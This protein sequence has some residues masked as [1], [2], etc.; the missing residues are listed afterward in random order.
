MSAN[1]GCPQDVE[2]ERPRRYVEMVNGIESWHQYGIRI[3]SVYPEIGGSTVVNAGTPLNL[4]VAVDV[5][6]DPQRAPQCIFASCWTNIKTEENPCGIW[7]EVFL[8]L[9]PDVSSSVH[10]NRDVLQYIYQA[11][12]VPTVCDTYR[13]TFLLKWN[14]LLLWF[15]EFGNDAFVDVV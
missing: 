6:R 10:D 11:S 5:R 9:N 14:H 13:M 3:P 12:L 8:P 4:H 1:Y 15:N 2:V 7:K